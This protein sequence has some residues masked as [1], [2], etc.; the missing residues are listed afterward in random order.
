MLCDISLQFLELRVLV[1]L[2]V[3]HVLLELLALV[4]GL[5]LLFLSAFDSVLQL[6]ERFLESFNLRAD[7][8]KQ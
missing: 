5:L 6:G 3:V 8:H 4:L 1:V 7:L 2:E